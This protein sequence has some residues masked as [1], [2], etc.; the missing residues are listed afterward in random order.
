MKYTEVNMDQRRQ[1]QILAG[2]VERIWPETILD[3]GCCNGEVSAFLGEVCHA[4]VTGV[5]CDDEAVNEAVKVIEAYTYSLEDY[6]LSKMCWVGHQTYDVIVF[7][8]VLEHLTQ[9]LDILRDASKLLNDGGHVLVSVPNVQYFQVRLKMAFGSMEYEDY[10]PLDRTHLKFF[11]YK[12]ARAL[13]EEAG[14]RIVETKFSV[15]PST[16]L[17]GALTRVAPSIFAYQFVF[18]LVMDSN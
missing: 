14:Y 11:G 17:F 7:A 2:M 5:D 4:R 15:K 3:V 12:S 10:G 8:D 1:H 13:V 18:D 16:W 6:P 9:P